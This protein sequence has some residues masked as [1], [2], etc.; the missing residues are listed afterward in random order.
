[1][2][3]RKPYAFLIKHF[4]AI[5]AILFLLVIFLF[6]VNLNVHTFVKEYAITGVYNRSLE[7]INI[8]LNGYF[9]V[10]NVVVLLL[11][12]ILLGL[13]RYK[14][15]PYFSYVYL[16]LSYAFLF[17]VT[18]YANAYF[19]GIQYDS[20][21]DIA[22]S[23]VV[24]DLLFLTSIPQYPALI[25]LLIRALGI[26]MKRFGF[27]EDKE[28]VEITSADNE[29]FEFEVGINQDQVKRN[30]RQKYRYFKYY[31]IEHKRPI[32]AAC[33]AGG[34]FFAYGTYRFVFVENK[35]YR[36][37]QTLQSNNYDITVKNTYLTDKDYA[38]NKIS[39]SGQYYFIAE[40]KVKNLQTTD[41]KFDI[42]K[43]FL[44]VGNHYYVPATR[45]NKHFEDMGDLYEGISLSGKEE[46]TYH[47]IYEIDP[48]KEG[49]NFYLA[50]QNLVG[51]S[52]LVKFKITVV[53]ISTFKTKDTKKL[54]E[55]LEIPLN[56]KEKKELT[57]FQYQI[58]DEFLYT[59][60]R[61][62]INDCPILEEKV[63]PS[64]GKTILYIKGNFGEENGQD[65]LAFLS[66]HGVLRYKVGD[67]FQ[68][69]KISNAVTK[70]YRGNYLYLSVSKN[71]EKASRIEILF[72]VRTYQYFYRLKG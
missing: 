62:Y 71:I 46:A 5:N 42:E 22:S 12:G 2:I 1:M 4:R 36:P 14:E 68:T 50:Y 30:L 60:Q 10:A 43:L 45:W 35:I 49:D 27:Q 40:V 37:N 16:F 54:S 38:G 20:T 26:D 7:S 48:P 69:E 13:L 3:L 24:R 58:G 47:L 19:G 57:L 67:T 72:T 33:I 65:F 56:E 39:S 31:V 66:K 11:T 18:L 53:D 70:K 23:R 44:Y 64:Q 55:T 21:F 8:Y 6:A 51:S 52:R 29:E 41:R 32:I 9:F 25:L 17:G 59:Y 28:F 61:C 63:K 34:L 15:K